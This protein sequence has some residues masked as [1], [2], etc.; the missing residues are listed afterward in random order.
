[1]K[2]RI[3]VVDDD[4]THPGKNNSAEGMLGNENDF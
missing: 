3:L 4:I 2:R 1:M